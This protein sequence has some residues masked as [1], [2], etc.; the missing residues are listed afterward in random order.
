MGMQNN[1]QK[2]WLITDFSGLVQEEVGAKIRSEGTME[3]QSLD[4]VKQYMG[5]T[6]KFTVAVK[7]TN[8]K[9]KPIA[10]AQVGLFVAHSN[11]NS[12]SLYR[13]T[14]SDGVAFFEIT[15]PKSGKLY[16]G[17]TSI[18]HPCYT[19]AKA[20]PHEKWIKIRV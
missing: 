1:D 2:I 19:S 16:A 10:L 4:V 11:D 20:K 3:I 6:R 17:V 14:D 8:K 15:D 7:V 12:M 5:E 18:K 9:S 13:Y